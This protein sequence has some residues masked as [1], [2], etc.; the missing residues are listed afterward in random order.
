MLAE[1]CINLALNLLSARMRDMCKHARP[2]VTGTLAALVIQ[3]T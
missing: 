1:Y 2:N 3:Q